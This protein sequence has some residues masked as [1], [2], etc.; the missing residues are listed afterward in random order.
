MAKRQRHI[1]ELCTYLFRSQGLSEERANLAPTDKESQDVT[2]IVENV[3]LMKS[4][5][6]HAKELPE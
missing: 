5:F 1:L 6:P 2:K 3:V 4:G